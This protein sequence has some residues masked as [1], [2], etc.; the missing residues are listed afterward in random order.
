M[1]MNSKKLTM[2]TKLKIHKLSYNEKK[3]VFTKLRNLMLSGHIEEFEDELYKEIANGYPIDFEPKKA[4]VSSLLIESFSAEDRFQVQLVKILLVAGADIDAVNNIG[5]N[6]LHKAINKIAVP[7]V[8]EE[9]AKRVQNI[10]AKNRFG[11][12]ALREACSI[13]RRSPKTRLS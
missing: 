6:A 7:E 8:I 12:T 3:T 2:S 5:D 4:D 1:S 9:L 13:Y 10:D 11:K